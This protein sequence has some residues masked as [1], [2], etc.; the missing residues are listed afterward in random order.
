MCFK[1]GSDTITVINPIDEN[2]C[3][4]KNIGNMR[5]YM[6]GGVNV[7]GEKFSVGFV[8]RVVSRVGLYHKTNDT[9]VTENKKSDVFNGVLGLDLGEFHRNLLRV[10]CNTLT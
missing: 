9:L 1:L 7:S 2:P 6:H 5:Q 3:S 10:Y 8:F 4:Q